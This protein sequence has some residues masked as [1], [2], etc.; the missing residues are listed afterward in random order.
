MLKTN[1]PFVQ[2]KISI[3]MNLR[4]QVKLLNCWL[5]VF[6]IPVNF[7]NINAPIVMFNIIRIVTFKLAN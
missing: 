1:A 7:H 4:H 3:L 6:I 5:S 2:S